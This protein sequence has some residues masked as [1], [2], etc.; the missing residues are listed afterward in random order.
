MRPGGAVAEAMDQIQG[1]QERGGHGH[2]PIDALA[3]FLP[4]LKREH[5][6]LETPTPIWRD[7]PLGLACKLTGSPVAAAAAQT[8]S[9]IWCK[10]GSGAFTQSKM[11]PVGRPKSATRRS[12]AAASSG[13]WQGSGSSMINRPADSA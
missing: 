5:G 8:G 2:S 4:T 12:S 11:T 9:H 1:I 13:V 7:P 6:R 10:T 3:T